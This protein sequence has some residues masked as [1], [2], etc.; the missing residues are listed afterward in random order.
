MS[1]KTVVDNF[2]KKGFVVNDLCTTLSFV[3]LGKKNLDLPT[4]SS[5]DLDNYFNSSNILKIRTE[6]IEDKPTYENEL[7]DVLRIIA[8]LTNF[9][10][11]TR[12]FSKI[13]ETLEMYQVT[14][15]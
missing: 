2:L 14:S 9:H 4:G 10:T 15:S 7:E 6:I 13:I 1:I 11:K 12:E 8:A 5:L 3:V